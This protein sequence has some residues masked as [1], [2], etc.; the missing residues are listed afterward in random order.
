MSLLPLVA[1]CGQFFLF[2][3]RSM[4]IKQEEK[5][6][7]QVGH[8]P[9]DPTAHKPTLLLD[10]TLPAARD[11]TIARIHPLAHKQEL[12]AT[13]C[14]SKTR[15]FLYI[16]KPLATSSTSVSNAPRCRLTTCRRDASHQSAKAASAG[17]TSCSHPRGCRINVQTSRLHTQPRVR[18]PIAFE[19]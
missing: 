3:L 11:D 5:R 7:I 4:C 18:W 16:H 1:F 2:F 14:R 17:G 6:A 10:A 9:R 19:C 13:P 8:P 15:V 12:P